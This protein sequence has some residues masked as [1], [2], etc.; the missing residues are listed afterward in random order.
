MPRRQLRAMNRNRAPTPALNAV[1]G[2]GASVPWDVAVVIP[3]RNEENRIQAC[4]VAMADAIDR[5]PATVGVI[6][7]V[8]DTTD[9]TAA[10]ASAIMGM[11]GI[12]H[13]ILDLKFAPGSGGVGRA[14]DLGC[15]LSQRIG[16]APPVL[17][18]T[19]A[20]SRV[21][22]AWISA[23]LAELDGADI[24]FGAIIPDPDE[25]S[26]IWPQLAR[27]G[28]IERDYTAAAMRLVSHLDPLPH[29]PDPQHRTPAGASIALTVASLERLGG[30]PWCSVSEDRV[31]AMRAEALDL[32]IRHS[33]KPKVMTSCRLTG[34]AEGGMATTLRERCG[35]DDPFCDDWLE[36]ADNMAAR[37]RTKGRLRAVWPTAQPCRSLARRLLGTGPIPDPEKCGMF[38]Q[39][40]QRLESTHPALVRKKLRHSDAAQELPLL[41]EHLARL[42]G[43]R[44]DLVPR[45]KETMFHIP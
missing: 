1:F 12:N 33:S 34:R 16:S 7:C 38:G 21:D 25:L 9:A 42:E 3:A 18:T 30:I 27:H 19:D 35:E 15:Q 39:F 37:Y 6:L 5:T 11:R 13:L 20:D 23:N 44:L 26:H 40:W 10:K 22:L 41:M 36:P 2:S 28:S 17:M 14:R 24:V 43:A 8:N 29:D 32:R 45:G 31:L 4:L